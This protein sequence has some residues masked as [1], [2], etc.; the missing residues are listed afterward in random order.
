MLKGMDIMNKNKH[1]EGLDILRA[2]A[3]IGVTLFHMFPSVF[4]GGYL[5]VVLF[6]VLTGF[7][8]TYTNQDKIINKSFSLR[9]YYK[10]RI[11]R[12]Y[13]HLLLMILTS[14][15][16]F[17]LFAKGALNNPKTEIFN[18][19][20]GLDNYYQIQQNLDY[21]TRI[22]NSSPFSH[23]W[24]LSIEIQFYLI[25]PFLLL[26]INRLRISKGKTQTNKIFITLILVLSLIMPIKYVLGTNVTSLYYGT[27]TRIF[28][29]LAGMFL[30]LI[31]KHKP[32]NT[33]FNKS[34]LCIALLIVSY[35]LFD[36]QSGI[37]YLCIMWFITLLSMFLIYFVANSTKTLNTTFLDWIGKHSYELYLWQ[38]PIIYLFQYLGWNK[39][40]IS[41]I[42][43]FIL[44]FV[45]V[46]WSNFLF[47]AIPLLKKKPKFK[48][49][50]IFCLATSLAIQC[51]GVYACFTIKPTNT[52]K[53]QEKIKKNKKKISKTNQS[54][55][56]ESV[57]TKEAKN[58][59]YSS[60][61][62]S[63]KVSDQGMVFLGDSVMLAASDAILNLYP[64]ASIDADVSRH[65]GE[66]Q[67]PYQQFVNEGKVHNT[68]VIALGTNGTLYDSIVEQTLSLIGDDHSIFWV[69]TYC[70]TCEWQDSNNAYLQQVAQN[71]SNVTIIDW[72]SL[73]KD[74]PEWL[75]DDGIHPN[76]EGSVQYA[77]LIQ[78][79]IN[80]VMN[81]QKELESKD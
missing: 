45:C 22:T 72:Y 44:L 64:D 65:V 59:D 54:N 62:N 42:F 14:L 70:P 26:G 20:L 37:V 61:G 31:Y 28:S 47:K 7:L 3:I 77:N 4:K 80:D 39:H 29:I 19:L 23:L 68:V 5:G 12:I 35:F 71:H 49:V 73:I 51:V 15:G 66:E 55:N 34:L 78:Q 52:N 74:H 67:Q 75:W 38:Y 10:S 40:F 69:N 11:K 76:D 60:S 8:L 63:A 33:N 81:K 36:G 43:E 41:Y 27:D 2:I 53:L 21:F 6:F 13:P 46:L 17:F 48:N 18:I 24:F 56:S 57:Q 30:G 1:I 50:I 32:Q 58:I 79:S 16:I 9:S 25:F